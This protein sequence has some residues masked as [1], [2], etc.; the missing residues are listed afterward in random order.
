MS[1]SASQRVQKNSTDQANKANLTGQQF[2]GTAGTGLTGIAQNG[3]VTPQMTSL[4]GQAAANN[5]SSVYDAMKQNLAR[6]QKIQ[7]GYAPGA[8]TDARALGRDTA[9]STSQAVNGANLGL[10]GLQSSN[11]LS[12]LQGL[13]GLSATELGTGTGDLSIAERAAAA[14]P[15]LLQQ[16][17]Q[18]VGIVG[19]IGKILNP[20]RYGTN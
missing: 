17:G 14:Q 5:V 20:G 13:S 10:A 3:G 19:G 6:R 18:G 12:A 7:G 11:R 1:K 16:I 4:T 9:A 15:G 8:G 2:A